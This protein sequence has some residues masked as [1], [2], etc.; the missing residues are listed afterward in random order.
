MYIISALKHDI[1]LR[2]G[3]QYVESV[4][5]A[6]QRD[7]RLNPSIEF[8]LELQFD[9]IGVVLDEHSD[10][11]TV[12][13][14]ASITHSLFNSDAINGLAHKA[15]S[16]A[17]IH[18]LRQRTYKPYNRSETRPPK[19]D[20]DLKRQSKITPC[21]SLSAGSHIKGRSTFS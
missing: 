12:G 21:A 19:N 18:A 17:T 1:R 14:K 7:A 8:P 2:P 4:L 3:V 10:D 5:Q 20:Y 11:Y 9:E 15:N 13:E 6:F 16:K